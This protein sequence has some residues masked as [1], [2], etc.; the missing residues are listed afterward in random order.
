MGTNS[1]YALREMYEPLPP[2]TGNNLLVSLV[3]LTVRV[4]KLFY[5]V[6]VANRRELPFEVSFESAINIV[7]CPFDRK[8][9]L[10][11]VCI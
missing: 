5:I 8:D 3:L 7:R 10:T 4:F 9:E 2:A 1:V 6:R 11:C